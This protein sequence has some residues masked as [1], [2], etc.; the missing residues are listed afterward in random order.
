MRTTLV[1]LVLGAGFMAA[2]ARP[3]AAGVDASVDLPSS[4]AAGGTLALRIFGPSTLAESRYPE[5][6]PV[7]IWAPGGTG[8]GSLQDPLKRTADVIRIVF[9][10]PG[11]RDTA[12]GRSSGGTYDNRG[13][14]SIAA[15]RDVILYAAGQLPDSLGRRIDDVLPIPVLHGNVGLLG[16]SN[17]GNIVVAAPA[18]AAG[19]LAGRLRYVIQWESPVSSQITLSD[20]GPAALDCSSPAQRVGLRA[21]NPHYRGFGPLELD[22]DYATLSFDPSSSTHPVFFDGN[23]DGRYTTAASTT[24][25]CRT[26]DVDGNGRIDLFEDFPLSTHS[27]G[28]RQYYSRPVTRALRDRGVFG[29]TWPPTVATVEE[30]DAYWDLREA[31][32]LYRSAEAGVPGLSAMVLASLEDHVQTAPDHPHIRQAFEGWVGANAWVRLNPGLAYLAAADRSLA[33]RTDLPELPPGAAPE[34]WSDAASYCMPEDV[35]TD[36]LQAAAVWE[37]ADRA[38]SGGL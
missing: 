4:A 5:G 2:G 33:A 28:G 26:P 34:S 17:G 35:T 12:T 9:L 13:P 11:G 22:V 36:A 32:R 10:F 18:L 1:A 15:L 6:A 27:V 3:A 29:R 8:E 31:V 25:G 16:S 21:V 30:A 38:R 7:V 23:G 20:L 24:S 19:A 37:M 14:G